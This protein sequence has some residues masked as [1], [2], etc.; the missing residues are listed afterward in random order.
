MV[1]H[2]PCELCAARATLPP[3]L[4]Q[5]PDDIQKQSSVRLLT[6][7]EARRWI[8]LG[9]MSARDRDV[10]SFR[11]MAEPE[12]AGHGEGSCQGRNM[13]RRPSFIVWRC[14]ALSR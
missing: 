5:Y 6:L 14:D 4:P 10:A 11:A 12:S 8:E 1:S 13:G 3:R 7:D 9:Y 2:S